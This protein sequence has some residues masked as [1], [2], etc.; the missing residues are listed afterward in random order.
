M[1]EY[2]EEYGTDDFIAFDTMYVHLD[3]PIFDVLSKDMLVKY[4]PNDGNWGRLWLL[5]GMK[6]DYMMR[7]FNRYFS[8]H[9]K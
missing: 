2:L 6:Q 5:M 9:D 3:T 1:D 7:T 4:Y 8:K